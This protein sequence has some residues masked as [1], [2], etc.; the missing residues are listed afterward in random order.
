MRMVTLVKLGTPATTGTKITIPYNGDTFEFLDP[1]WRGLARQA[2]CVPDGKLRED[3][4][5]AIVWVKAQ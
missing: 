1:A 5:V 2:A 3:N 4:R